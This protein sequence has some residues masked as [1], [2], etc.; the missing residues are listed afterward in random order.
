MAFHIV[1]VVAGCASL[2]VTL[3]IVIVA[4]GA[5]L[6]VTLDVVVAVRATA[7]MRFVT[8]D[9]VVVARCLRSSVAPSPP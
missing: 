2:P 5:G 4:D 7:G 8:L 9:V 6:L 1:L 3:D